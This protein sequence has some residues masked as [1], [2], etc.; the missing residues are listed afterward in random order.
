MAAGPGGTETSIYIEGSLKRS[1]CPNH[2]PEWSSQWEFWATLHLT[3]KN[4]FSSWVGKWLRKLCS[5]LLL[6]FQD[7]N[8]ATSYSVC[9]ELT[10][11]VYPGKYQCLTGQS[12]L[13]ST[14]ECTVSQLSTG[15]TTVSQVSPALEFLVPFSECHT[16]TFNSCLWPK[17]TSKAQGPF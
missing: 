16:V 15:C 14:A 6:R 1:L 13:K 9:L 11:E 8:V 3:P 12:Q 2:G 4:H 7:Y 10:R 5:S 17:V